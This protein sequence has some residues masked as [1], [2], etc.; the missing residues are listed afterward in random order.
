ML[1]L[2]TLL[3]LRGRALGLALNGRT[4]L[5]IGTRITPDRPLAPDP[6]IRPA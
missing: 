4:D 5:V 1:A 3:P 6:Q 2:E